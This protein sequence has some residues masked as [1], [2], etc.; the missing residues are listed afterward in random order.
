MNNNEPPR[1][2]PTSP[3]NVGL[4]F[5]RLSTFAFVLMWIPFA[6]MVFAAI[7]MGEGSY[8]WDEMTPLLRA[9]LVGTVSLAGAAS[10]LVVLSGVL[11]AATN[12]RLRTHGVEAPATLLTCSDTG[13]R[14]NESPMVAFSLRVHPPGD[15]PFEAYAE[16]VVSPL[17][18]HRLDPGQTLR[19]KYDPGTR[20]VA[21]LDLG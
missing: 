10:I 14:I 16:Q 15:A 7:Q 13:E 17:H 20:E 19:V 21:I 6:G 11:G 4:L 18:L 5:R 2:A 3:L 8:G 12:K 9:S 1:G